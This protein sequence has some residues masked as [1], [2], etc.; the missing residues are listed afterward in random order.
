M[1][2]RKPAFLL[3]AAIVF[4]AATSVQ[5]QDHAARQPKTSSVRLGDKVIVIPD[6]EG[7]EEGTAQ[8]PKI[9]ELFTAVEAP[10][11]D[12]L[13]AH[14]PAS[15]CTTLRNGSEVFL[16][17]YTKVSVLKA[18]RELAVSDAEMTATVTE[19]RKNG[20][21]MLEPDGPLVTEVMRNAERGLTKLK[22]R[23]I[24]LDMSETQN[25]GEFDVRPEVY[26]VLLLM[27][28]KVDSQGKQES[29]PMLA[30]LSFLKVRQRVVY[31]NV[32]H[33]L[34][35]TAAVKTEMKPVMKEMTQF[36]RKWVDDILAANKEAQ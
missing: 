36:T 27:T 29:T 31:L 21:K 7:Y 10:S 1:K 12:M 16:S 19:F 23:E 28:I 22:S 6:P 4:A 33:K 35:S 18:A 8:F 34:S 26:S 17:R 9:K 20:T 2:L 30:T 11:N 14:L 25:L 24:G 3:A 5:A 32:Y 15:D 13:L